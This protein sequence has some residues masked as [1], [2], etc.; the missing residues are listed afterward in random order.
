M[1]D[2]ALGAVPY[3]VRVVV[4]MLIHRTTVQTLYGQG[5]GRYS[6]DETQE[7]RVEAWNAVNDLLVAS[8]A[9]K[10]QRQGQQG[11]ADQPFWVLGGEEPTE[12]DTTVFGFVISALVCTAYAALPFFG[13][14]LPDADT[15]FWRI[16]WPENEGAG[17][18]IPRCEGVCKRDP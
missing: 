15:D 4:G 8:K 17:D 16:W 3:F 1:R 2:Y 5:T 7:F 14:R 18:G 13:S 6:A 11:E 10:T 12:A 9:K